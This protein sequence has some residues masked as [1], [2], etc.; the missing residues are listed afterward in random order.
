VFGEKLAHALT[1]N[2]AYRHVSRDLRVL[3]HLD[4][5]VN[6]LT[7][8]D[9]KFRDVLSREPNRFHIISTFSGD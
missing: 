8:S 9:A 4:N 6:G 7:A 1:I 2:I 3:T 5:L